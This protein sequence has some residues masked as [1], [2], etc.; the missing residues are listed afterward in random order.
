MRKSHKVQSETKTTQI[1]AAPHTDT[2]KNRFKDTFLLTLV[3]IPQIFSNI[4]SVYSISL[5][6]LK[7]LPSVYMSY[8]QTL[9]LLWKTFLFSRDYQV[10]CTYSVKSKPYHFR[11]KRAKERTIFVQNKLQVCAFLPPQ[12]TFWIV[13]LDLLHSYQEDIYLFFYLFWI[14]SQKYW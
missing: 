11:G 14:V 9:A 10:L 4:W 1:P 8:K 2:V 7:F 3:Q 12:L 13:P 6:G 5:Q